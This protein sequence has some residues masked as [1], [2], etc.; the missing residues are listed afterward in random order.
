M[1]IMFKKRTAQEVHVYH[2]EF[3]P[4]GTTA[5][6]L[7]W[8]PSSASWEIIAMRNL[9]PD[10]AHC[11]DYKTRGITI[12]MVEERPPYVDEDFMKS[13]LYPEDED[14]EPLLFDGD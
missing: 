12:S 7:C 9:V 5:R 14:D 10:I 4:N 1:H 13:I 2:F 8:V 3:N 6:A 11:T